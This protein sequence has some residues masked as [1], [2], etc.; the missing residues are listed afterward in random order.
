MQRLPAC[1]SVLCIEAS[2]SRPSKDEL[3]IPE[4]SCFG[5]RGGKVGLSGIDRV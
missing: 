2:Q 1:Y 5:A 4:N 3:R